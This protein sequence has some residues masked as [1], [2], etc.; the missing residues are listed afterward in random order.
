VPV[1]L[2]HHAA[3]VAEEELHHA[4]LERLE[5]RRGAERAAKG[6]VLGRRERREHV[7]GLVQL[8]HDARHPREHL[9]RRLQVVGS[10][11]IARCGELVDHQLQPELGCLVLHD[12][13]HLV[14]VARERAL[15]AQ[16]GLELE[17][18]AVAH[19]AGEI[20]ARAVGVLG[21]GHRGE[22][23]TLVSC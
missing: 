7:P 10:N 21:I 23:D 15:R 19:R 11:V 14:V 1:R 5:A 13:Q 16:H 8:R 20:E 17:I 9:E 12:E 18:V 6:R 4:V 2:H 3:L 22:D